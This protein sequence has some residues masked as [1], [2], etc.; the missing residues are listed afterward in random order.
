M[1][2]QIDPALIGHQHLFS[3]LCIVLQ[4]QLRGGQIIALGDLHGHG[5]VRKGTDHQQLLA[6]TVP[7]ID[8]ELLVGLEMLR[9]SAVTNHSQRFAQMDGLAV[10][11]E[12][13]VGIF[14]LLSG[15]D[16]GVVGIDADPGLAG[17]EARIGFRRPLDGGPGIV[18]GTAPICPFC[19]TDF[20]EK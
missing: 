1:V 11:V 16:P 10:E 5:L 7:G 8:I 9:I 14:F 4:D 13:G 19:L 6:D 18:T 2:P 20:L 17:G 12:D 15:I 3:R